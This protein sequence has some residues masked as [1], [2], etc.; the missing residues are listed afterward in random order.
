MILRDYQKELS[1][2]AAKLLE[3]VKIAY[4]AME[5]RCGKTYTS[6]VA[7][8][9]IGAKVVLFVTRKK[10]MSSIQD[11]YDTMQPDFIIDIINYESLHLVVRTDYDIIIVDESHSCG[12]FPT[13]PERVK[14][15]RKICV[16]KP[17]IFLSATPTP[18]SFSQLYH[19]LSIS[20]FSPF[21]EWPTFYK[22]AKAGFVNVQKKYYFNREIQDYSSANK[23]KIDEYTKH[24]FITYTQLQSGFTEMVQEEILKVRM[25]PTTYGLVKNLLNKRIYIG[26]GGEEILA[27]TAVKLQNK[28]HQIYSGTVIAE[29]KNGICFDYSKARFIKEYFK[30]RKIAIFYK[31][32]CEGVMLIATF[33]FNNLTEDPM[34]FNERSDKIFYSQV[35]SGREGTNLSTADALVF[36]NIDFSSVSYQQARARIQT[37][38]RTKAAMLYWIFSENGIEEKILERVKAKQDYTLNYFLKDFNVKKQY[39]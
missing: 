14:L 7:C 3:W 35:Q 1:T 19:Q 5:P 36:F 16:G 13:M 4:L 2:D 6:F 24:L 33:G 30:G 8:V 15:L 26:K 25:M 18:E 22:W 37:Q 27:D 32:K 39:V 31:F 28:L 20:S 38:G 29:D 12:A 10:A 21:K 17:V 9:K 34:E 23:D 11:D